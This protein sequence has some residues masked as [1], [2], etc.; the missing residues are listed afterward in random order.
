VREGES[1]V[2]DATA[3]IALDFALTERRPGGLVPGHSFGLRSNLGSPTAARLAGG[4]PKDLAIALGTAFR[5]GGTESSN[6]ASSRRE[7]VANRTR[8]AWRRA[9]QSSRGVFALPHER[10]IRYVPK[11]ETA[12]CLRRGTSIGFGSFRSPL[13]QIRILTRVRKSSINWRNSEQSTET[14][15][16]SVEKV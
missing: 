10:K 4:L 16:N 3:L 11:G 14:V 2:N 13:R 15:D 8:S 12:N 7:S 5:S 9:A 6:P 1:L